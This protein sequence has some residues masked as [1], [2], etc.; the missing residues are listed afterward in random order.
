MDFRV[1]TLPLS[2]SHFGLVTIIL[3]QNH[4]DVY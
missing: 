3:D 2:G 1:V 4:Y